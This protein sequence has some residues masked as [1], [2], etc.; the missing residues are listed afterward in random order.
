MIHH[1]A[2]SPW[3]IFAYSKQPSVY[4][5]SDSEMKSFKEKNTRAEIAELERIVEEREKS[6]VTLKA[7]IAQLKQELPALPEETPQAA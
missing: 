2:S 6:I 7:T 1:Y 5:I 4:V 3:D